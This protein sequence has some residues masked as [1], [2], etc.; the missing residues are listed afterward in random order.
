MLRSKPKARRSS[1]TPKRPLRKPAGVFFGTS[2]F[3]VPALRAFA[4]SLG[5]EL[6]VTQPDRPAGRGH[7][8]QPTPVKR[9]ARELGI[10]TIEPERLRDA[11]PALAG[12]GADLFAVASYGKIV[13]QA[14]LDLPRAGALNVH[15]SLLPLYRGA[16]PLQGQLR[17]GVTIGGVTIIV[18]VA[19]MDTGDIALAERAPI[20][21]GETYGEL[22]DRFGEIGATLLGRACRAALDGTLTRTPQRGLASE[23]AI[24]RTTTRP[25]AKD[26]LVTQWAWPAKRIV[27]HVRSL[28]P[29]PLA[30]ATIAGEVVKLVRVHA[31]PF[32]EMLAP[33]ASGAVELT[34][35]CADGAIVVDRLIPPNRGEMGGA[36]YAQRLR[37][38]VPTSR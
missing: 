23:E 32:V 3:A 19:G 36:A 11:L 4:Q 24:A 7:K 15:P 20:G 28:S 10:P 27:D 13:P 30:R 14:M 1:G 25:L 31:A 18:M 5:C 37:G 35:P 26:D 29:A 12:I 33:P 8:L 38:Q 6:V 34:V 17:D 22:A 16:T 21:P 9:A 2:A